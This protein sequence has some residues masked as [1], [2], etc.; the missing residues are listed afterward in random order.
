MRYSLYTKEKACSSSS[1]VWAILQLNCSLLSKWGLKSM[2]RLICIYLFLWTALFFCANIISNL[3]K[4]WLSSTCLACHIFRPARP[5]LAG[6]GLFRLRSLRHNVP[7]VYVGPEA[8]CG[9]CGHWSL[10]SYGRDKPAPAL[11]TCGFW[12]RASHWDPWRLYWNCSELIENLLLLMA[13]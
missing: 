11:R 8:F 9:C 3:A 4:K 5:F 2:E 13:S 6:A 7:A 12:H 1:C 10:D